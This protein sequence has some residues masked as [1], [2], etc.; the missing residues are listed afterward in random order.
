MSKVDWTDET[1]R[2]LADA[3][4]G[5]SFAY[6]KELVVTSLMRSILGEKP[7]IDVVTRE[8]AALAEQMKTA[9]DAVPAAAVLDV[10]DD[11]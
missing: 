1:T 3:T 2:T 9:R 11:E 8:R 4:A 7:W 6:I 5:F 10:D